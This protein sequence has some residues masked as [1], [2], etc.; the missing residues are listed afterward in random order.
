M[1]LADELLADLD[2]DDDV[3]Y[4][5]SSNPPGEMGD[6]DEIPNNS[7]LGCI[8]EESMEIDLSSSIRKLATVYDSDELKKVMAEIDKRA[9]ESGDIFNKG[10]LDGPVED[11][12]EYKLIVETNNLTVAIDDDINIIHKYVKD[13]Y[14][15]RFPELDSLIPT[16]LEYL[17]TVKEL[18]NDL[19]KA[20]N[21]EILQNFLPQATIMILSVSASTTQGDQLNAEELNSVT[22][23][24]DMA[25]ELNAKKLKIFEFV[26]SRMSFIAPNVSAI[27]GANIAAKLMGLAGGLT[28]LS[29]MPACNVEVLG[30]KKRTLAGF[31][32]T[33]ILPHTGFVFQT[34]I[35]Q[36]TP[37]DFRRKAAH[38][39]ANKCTIAARIDACHSSQDGSQGR[40]LREKIER[41]LDKLLEPPPV[42]Q[43]KPL[44]QPI[45]QPRKKRG[46]KR[47]RRI[48]ERMAMTE[49]RKQINRMNF[50][51]IEE[52][53][54]QE[55]LGFTTGQIGK[56]AMGRI[57]APQI[58]EKTKVK[59]S[60][61]L[62]KQMQKTSV[63]G[64]TT[65]IKRQISGTASSVAFTPLKGIEIVNPHAAEA[66]TNDSGKYFS[67]TSGFR[68]VVRKTT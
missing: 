60:K 6:E 22:E 10:N 34:D 9:G 59:I 61:T 12:P 66:K 16:A 52:D 15:Q 21:N 62:H 56:S 65:T 17:M 38:L 13:K 54:Y 3:G 27:V 39:V 43:V 68:S 29:K 23:A 28:N 67:T 57:R 49:F 20:K 33:Q 5:E 58:D 53:A 48:K 36:E 32:S 51:E 26:E 2:G 64:G 8:K 30:S 50:G 19:D 45:D 7:V 11:H 42:K 41:A 14:S 1:S 47:V 25:I 31:S 24:C 55:D 46:G 40:I 35:V 18:G 4:Y 44:P 37:A 63:Y